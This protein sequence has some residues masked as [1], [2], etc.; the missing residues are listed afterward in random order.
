MLWSDSDQVIYNPTIMPENDQFIIPTDH[1]RSEISIVKN[2]LA[3]RNRMI[4]GDSRAYHFADKIALST[5]WSMVP[6]RSYSGDMEWNLAGQ[7]DL[8]LTEYTVDGG[9]GGVQLVEWY[10]NH[11]GAFWVF[12]SYDNYVNFDT[13]RYDHLDQYSQVK[14][15]YFASFDYAIVKRGA[16]NHD[17]W[18][19][20]VTL[21]EV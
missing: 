2:R 10:E 3:N 8:S 1:N 20:S 17:L 7:K 21:E 15:M 18:N 9:A 4:N 11:P 6:S 5:S 16:T 19:V 14:K 13:D 12:L